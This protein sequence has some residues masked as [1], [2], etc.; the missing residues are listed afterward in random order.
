MFRATVALLFVVLSGAAAAQMAPLEAVKDLA[1]TGT[2][3]AAINL[4]NV[5]LAQKD[6]AGQP[7]GITVDL[8]RELARRL[9]TP[10]E[11]VPFDA[12]GKT[13]EALKTG[14][15]DVL[16]LAIEPVRANEIAFTAPYVIIEGSYMVPRDSPLTKNEE[17]D[18]PGIRI[19][20]NRGSAYDLFLTR[21]LKQAELV[22]SANGMESLIND[23]LEAAAGVKQAL[24]AFAAKRSDLRLI[25]GHFMEIR[26]AMG[27]PK[28]RE[29]GALYLRDFVE[30]MKRSGFVAEAVKRH[31]QN[32]TLAP[33]AN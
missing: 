28:E 24:V 11:L 33:P 5:V 31:N 4:G 25:D 9:G 30:E 10:M 15:L 27:T 12:A 1:P 17:L 2:L 16:F 23:K 22:R 7:K 21:T 26:Q 29:K 6:E 13:F 20:V 8:A 32:V 18:R 19:G 3:R 14:T